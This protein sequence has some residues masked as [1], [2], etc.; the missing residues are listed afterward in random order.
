MKRLFS[1]H[2]PFKFLDLGKSF[3]HFLPSTT[4]LSFWYFVEMLTIYCTLYIGRSTLHTVVGYCIVY[5]YLS[6][7]RGT[8]NTTVQYLKLVALCFYRY[9]LLLNDLAKIL[10]TARKGIRRGFVNMQ[11]KPCPI[12]KLGSVLKYLELA[13]LFSCHYPFKLDWYLKIL[14]DF[15]PLGLKKIQKFFKKSFF[16]RTFRSI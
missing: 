3:L 7:H 2:I 14:I 11:K 5:T 16:H 8:V 9:I 12:L 4:V 1:W 15:I 13:L 10:I 6:C